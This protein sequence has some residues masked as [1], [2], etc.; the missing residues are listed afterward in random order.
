M[1]YRAQGPAFVNGEKHLDNRFVGWQEE[2]ERAILTAPDEAAFTAALVAAAR[3]LGFEYCAFGLRQPL[4]LSNPKISLVNNYSDDWR[5]R[6]VQQNYLA[7]DPSVAH[8]LKSV[9]PLVWNDDLFKSSQPFWEEACEHGLKVGWAQSMVDARGAVGML[10]L[11]RSSEAL[12]AAELRNNSLLMRSLV[13]AAHQGMS[14][15]AL[16]QRP[17]P[18]AV[19]LTA[20]EIEVLRWTAEGKTSGEVAQIMEI[21]ERTVNFHVTNSLEKLGANNKTAGVIRAVMLRLL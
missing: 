3:A 13:Q 2:H 11:A 7:V 8:G 4:P 15:L 6:Y 20:R 10:T 21:S 19:R 9:A 14:R 12:S 1:A 18:L 5:Q 16:E 17:Q